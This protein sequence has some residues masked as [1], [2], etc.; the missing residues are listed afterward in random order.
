MV[1][2]TEKNFLPQ[3]NERAISMFLPEK[4]YMIGSSGLLYQCASLIKN[5]APDIPQ[6]LLETG[7][8][9]SDIRRAEKHEA[10]TGTKKE[11]MAI[12]ENEENSSI[13]FS[14]NNPYII[15]EVIVNKNNFIMIN[16]HHALLPDHPGR[17]AEAW[18][19]FDG[20]KKAGITWHKIDSGTDS[21]NILI[22]KEVLIADDTTSISLLKQLNK[23]AVEALRELLPLDQ[24]VKNHGIIQQIPAKRIVRLAK[25]IPENGILSLEWDEAKISRFLRSMDYSVLNVLG[26]P[27]ILVG[28][29]LRNIESYKIFSSDKEISPD[30]YQILISKK[31]LQFLLNLSE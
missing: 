7:H 26:K 18:S 28:D 16:L 31:T 24:L 27:R 6:I 5:A 14:I 3:Q 13:L 4:I 11:L 17:N 22:Q 15:P 23:L 10:I 8:T 20:D 29:T 19:I 25:D 1:R 2:L 21:G 12:L 9:P 30:G